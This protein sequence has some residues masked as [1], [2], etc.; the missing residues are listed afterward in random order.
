[1]V[2]LICRDA[3]HVRSVHAKA[4]DLGAENAG[5][6]ETF[7]EQFFG[8]YFRDLDGNKVCVFVMA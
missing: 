3:D 6:P 5:S 8:G 4:L 2:A 7:G 1:M